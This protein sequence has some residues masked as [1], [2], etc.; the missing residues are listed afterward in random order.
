MHSVPSASI[1]SQDLKAGRA[2]GA[3][4]I[5]RGLSEVRE[6]KVLL[7]GRVLGPEQGGDTT[8]AH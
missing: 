4:S 6:G 2:S 5:A 7:G 8:Q 1:K 3:G